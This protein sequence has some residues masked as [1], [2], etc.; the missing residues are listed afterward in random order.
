MHYFLT[1]S[2]QDFHKGFLRGKTLCK[3]FSYTAVQ[4]QKVLEVRTRCKELHFGNTLTRNL[5]LLNIFHDAIQTYVLMNIIP[6]FFFFFLCKLF[7]FCFMFHNFTAIF[8]LSFYSFFY[9]EMLE[10]N[11]LDPVKHL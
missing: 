5:M 10:T 8:S 4:C 3:Y 7:H 6:V 9:R 11:F 1:N 2:F